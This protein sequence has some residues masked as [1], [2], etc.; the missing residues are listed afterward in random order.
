M[1]LSSAEADVMTNNAVGKTVSRKKLRS[2]GQNGFAQ[3][4]APYI[5]LTP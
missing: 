3:E 5:A 4:I 1:V 2:G